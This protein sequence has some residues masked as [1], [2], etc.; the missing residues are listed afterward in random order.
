MSCDCK[1]D[2]FC[3]RYAREMIGRLRQICAGTVLT[4]EKCAAYRR[5]WQ[6]DADG[7][8]P[9]GRQLRRL[10][11]EMEIVGEDGCDCGTKAKQM[12][13][14]EVDGCREH[15][16]EIVEWMKEAA[17]TKGWAEKIKVGA[18]L[19]AQPWFNPLDSYGSIVDEAIRLADLLVQQSSPPDHTVQSPPATPQSA[20]Q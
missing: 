8:L 9:P 5:R 2:G 17:A 7:R 14:W 4:P 11:A 19:L 3:A 12:D 1:A 15:R 13:L 6:A 10:L 16:A 18:K 20:P